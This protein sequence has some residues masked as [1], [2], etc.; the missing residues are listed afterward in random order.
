VQTS[1]SPGRL[2]C[3]LNRTVAPAAVGG[4]GIRTYPP[5][6][7]VA[8]QGPGV[9]GQGPGTGAQSFHGGARA[10]VL[11]PGRFR[12]GRQSARQRPGRTPGHA[13]YITP[14]CRVAGPRRDHVR[15]SVR[16]T[17][18]CHGFTEAV[19]SVTRRQCLRCGKQWHTV[20]R[21][22]G[23]AVRNSARTARRHEVRRWTGSVD[24]REKRGNPGEK[25]STLDPPTAL[26][27]ATD[28]VR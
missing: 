5:P 8:V 27:A 9:R 14:T 12:P 17:A 26:V 1:G 11:S 4:Y 21:N 25:P 6:R 28:W 7:R 22:P 24:G 3:L 15:D 2:P 16:S 10:Y 23:Q 18:V 13:P 20:V 19:H